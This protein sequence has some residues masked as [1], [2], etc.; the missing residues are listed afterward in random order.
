MA[1]G[2][3]EVS[4]DVRGD[5]DRRVAFVQVSGDVDLASAAE[6]ETALRSPECK[7]SPAV[8]LDLRGVPFMDSSGLQVLLGAVREPG[9]RLVVVV[10]DG[11]A[12][13]RLFDLTGVAEHLEAVTTEQEALEAVALGERRAEA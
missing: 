10:G 13:A 4:T 5:P 9:N 1:P 3:L 8:V 6:L 2:D 12:V 11:S 7:A